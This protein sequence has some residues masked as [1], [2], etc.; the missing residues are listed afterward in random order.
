MKKTYENTFVQGRE[1]TK[2]LIIATVISCVMSIVCEQ[3]GSPVQPLFF[4]LTVLI[5]AA[6]IYVMVKYCRCP[7]CGKRIMFGVLKITV[8]PSCRR[9]LITGKKAKKGQF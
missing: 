8:C 2:K 4:W 5:F 1:L 6:V 7:H 9:S 3:I